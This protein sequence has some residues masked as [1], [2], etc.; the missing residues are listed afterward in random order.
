[1]LPQ[2]VESLRLVCPLLKVCHALIIF[3]KIV[4][5]LQ[6]TVRSSSYLQF[7]HLP[8]SCIYVLILSVWFSGS[9]YKVALISFL[10]SSRNSLVCWKVTLLSYSYTLSLIIEGHVLFIRLKLVL[11]YNYGALWAKF[12]PDVLNP[13]VLICWY[14]RYSRNSA[15]PIRASYTNLD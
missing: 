7:H 2:S 6:P 3:I 15:N 10:H 5:F 13:F 11:I 8:T 14:L 12:Q 1:M 4:L 9:I